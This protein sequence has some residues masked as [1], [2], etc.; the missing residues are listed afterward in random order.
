MQVAAAVVLV[1]LVAAAAVARGQYRPPVDAPVTDPFRPPATPYGPGNRGL[2]YDT[3]PGEPVRAAGDGR[4]SFAGTVAGRGVVSVVHPDGLRS[5]Y[6]G[7]AVVSV[8]EGD[9]VAGG[10]PLGRAGTTMHLGFLRGD[11][12]VDPSGLFDQVPRVRL[13]A[14]M[15]G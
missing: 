8:G 7:L 11:T 5:T 1:V 15:T 13:I 12:Y 4:V 2:E 14:P 9:P 6:T 10:Q 3:R